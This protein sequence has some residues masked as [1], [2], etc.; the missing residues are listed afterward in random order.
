MV[1]DVHA[2]VEWNDRL[3]NSMVSVPTN[4]TFI[5]GAMLLILPC[6]H[7]YKYGAYSTSLKVIAVQVTK[8]PFC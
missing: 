6:P 2:F 4:F 3:Y 1:H 5:L 7:S 8:C